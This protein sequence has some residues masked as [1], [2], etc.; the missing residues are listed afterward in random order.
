MSQQLNLIQFKV[1][2]TKQ[3]LVES[4]EFITPISEGSHC[5]N[6][7]GVF[8]LTDGGDSLL[9]FGNVYLFIGLPTVI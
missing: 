2:A 5:I 9:Q 4:F 6:V 3:Y 1:V 7:E 8:S